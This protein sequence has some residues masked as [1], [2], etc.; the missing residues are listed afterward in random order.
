MKSPWKFLLD[1]A[2]RGR[3]AGAAEEA[4]KPETEYPHAPPA[5]PGFAIDPSVPDEP[6]TALGVAPIEVAS[7][8]GAEAAN[9]AANVPAGDNTASASPKSADTSERIDRPKRK[10]SRR[11]IRAKKSNAAEVA[12]AAK[13]EYGAANSDVHVP[14][15]AFFDEATA[16]DGDIKQLR[17][18]LAEKLSL[19]NAQL[20]KLLERF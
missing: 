7:D 9:S 13:V 2:S 19:Q 6:A 16:L 15:S 17:Q 20:R 4:T 3:A 14:Q 10:P 18:D 1:L 5:N 8:P 12:V 11:Q